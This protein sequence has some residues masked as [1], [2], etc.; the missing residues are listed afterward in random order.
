MTQNVLILPERIDGSAKAVAIIK[1][2]DKSVAGCA[3]VVDAKN[4]K[5]A[6]LDFFADFLR[7]SFKY[8]K[9]S[10]IYF[11]NIDT[12]YLGSIKNAARKLGVSNKIG[13]SK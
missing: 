4:V 6:S 3:L 2:I 7:L 13:I 1:T 12:V 9:V 5:V 8:L 10:S 11:N